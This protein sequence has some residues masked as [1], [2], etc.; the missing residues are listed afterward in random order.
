MSDLAQANRVVSAIERWISQSPGERSVT[1]KETS[2]GWQASMHETKTAG[3]SSA[4]DA[5]TQVA[6]VCEVESEERAG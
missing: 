6:V 1:I 3:G 4:L 5:L 2:D